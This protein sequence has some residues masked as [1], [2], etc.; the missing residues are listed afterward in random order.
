MNLETIYV[1]DSPFTALSLLPTICLATNAAILLN[2]CLLS[3][4]TYRENLEFV[5]TKVWI[6]RLNLKVCNKIMWLVTWSVT[7]EPLVSSPECSKAIFSDDSATPSHFFYFLITTSKKSMTIAEFTNWFH[8][9]ACWGLIVWNSSPT[10]VVMV[11]DYQLVTISEEEK[12]LERFLP[13]GYFLPW[14]NFSSKDNKCEF[15]ER[16]KGCLCHS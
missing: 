15:C 10:A 14:Q 1:L 2:F 5:K 12:M 7:Q 16:N 8:N 6:E 3:R 9:I 4:Y 13:F 11:S